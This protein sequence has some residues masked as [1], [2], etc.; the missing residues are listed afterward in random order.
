MAS[1]S[2][3]VPVSQSLAESFRQVLISGNK[4]FIKVQVQ[5]EPTEQLIEVGSQPSK[6]NFEDDFALVPPVLEAKNPAFI[7][8]RSDKQAT[9]GYEFF[10][11]CYV[12]DGCKAREKMMYS[13]SKGTLKQQLGANNFVDSIHGTIPDDF[14]LKGYK[15]HVATQNMDAPLTESEIL[16]KEQKSAHTDFNMGTQYVHGVSFPVTDAAMDKLQ[17]LKNGSIT[18]VQLK[19]DEKAEK[20]D[21]G[22]STNINIG[23]IGSQFPD[24]EARFHFFAYKHEFEGQRLTSVIFIYS[25]SN[26]TPVKQR[27]LY[28]TTKAAATDAATSI[29]IEIAKKLEVNSAEELTE[30][31]I[32]DEIHPPK[33]EEKKAFAKPTKPG[34]GG[35]KLV[36]K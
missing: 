3:N 29:G 21:L 28:S 12:P 32:Y 16:R 4:R 35:R 13:S 30:Q 18:Y 15:Q 1:H 27:M 11:L 23:E 20:I 19:I 24:A 36:T 34:K 8:Y 10:L 33:V 31:A 14:S 7:I 5:M 6:G 2:S 26:G 25:C 9:T 22:T 17:K